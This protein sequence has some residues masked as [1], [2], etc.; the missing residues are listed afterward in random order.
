MS[1]VPLVSGGIDS[2]VMCKLLEKQGQ[3]L[4]PIFINYGQLSLNN[5]WESCKKVFELSNLTSPEYI[6]IQGYGNFFKS[7]ITDKNKKIFD[8]AFLPGRNLIFLIIAGSYSYQ[9]DINTISIG[10]LSEQNHL[11]P[12]QTEEFI[13]NTNFALNSAYGRDF[14]IITPLIN[15]TKSEVI[16]IAKKYELPLE[17]TY[18]CHS[19]EMKYCEECIA[20]KEIISSG[21][22]ELLPQFN[23]R[24]D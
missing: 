11:F 14:T 18:S 2:L 17:K 15:F 6:N 8:E 9:N 7:G 19:G 16:E 3:K 24:G 20:C 23:K 12:D 4:Y 13:V 5:E 10:L 1:V 21:N 22:K